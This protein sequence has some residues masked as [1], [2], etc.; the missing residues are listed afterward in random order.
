MSERYD[1]LTYGQFM[2]RLVE[3]ERLTAAAAAAAAAA[4][5][6]EALRAQA[7]RQLLEM[8]AHISRHAVHADDGWRPEDQLA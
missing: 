5:E 1:R 2:S 7:E 3:L 4:A 8:R 6:T